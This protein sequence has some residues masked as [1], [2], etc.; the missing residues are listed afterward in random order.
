MK[1]K[2][3][4]M[5]SIVNALG[6]NTSFQLKRVPIALLF[7]LQ[8]NM[9]ELNQTASAYICAQAEIRARYKE[10]TE[11]YNTA[12]TELL[13]VESELTITHVPTTIL[14]EWDEDKYDALTLKEFKALK[15]MTEEPDEY[16]EDE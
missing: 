1:I 9:P 11:E 7:A 12:L 16:D 8:K 4:E 5:V 2:N 3:S 14:E 10:G 6:E 15:F 13:N